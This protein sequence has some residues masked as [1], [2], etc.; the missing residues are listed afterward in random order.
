MT[1]NH[2]FT[3]FR[4]RRRLHFKREIRDLYALSF[5][6]YLLISAAVF[7]Y[8]GNK[9]ALKQVAKDW[10]LEQSAALFP[11][12]EVSTELLLLASC[13]LALQISLRHDLIHYA[14][15]LVLVCASL[16]MLPIMHLVIQLGIGLSPL[17][18]ASP[19]ELYMLLLQGFFLVEYVLVL[20]ALVMLGIGIYRYKIHSRQLLYPRLFTLFV[21]YKCLQWAGILLFMQRLGLPL[22]P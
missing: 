14:R 18:H 5:Y 20:P 11:Y 21:G 2:L 3:R 19:L 7:L 22:W 4:I 17:S 6:L 8:I 10:S 13:A 15:L 1:M 12:Q 9:I 16:A